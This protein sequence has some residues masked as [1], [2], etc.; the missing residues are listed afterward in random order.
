MIKLT[1][2]SSQLSRYDATRF[3]SRTM[4]Q[5]SRTRIISSNC[6]LL[7]NIYRFFLH[8]SHLFNYWVKHTRTKTIWSM[9]NLLI[10]VTYVKPDSEINF[11]K[12]NTSLSDSRCAHKKN[13]SCILAIGYENYIVYLHLQDFLLL[14]KML[15][16]K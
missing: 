15:S 3:I 13:P 6:I 9:K 5:V 1:S 8:R 2:Y 10:P 14:G 7:T 4:K 12:I 16:N 11:D